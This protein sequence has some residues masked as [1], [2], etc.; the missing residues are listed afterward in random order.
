MV[1]MMRQ[2]FDLPHSV[3]YHYKGIALGARPC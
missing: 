3:V 2:F 1:Q